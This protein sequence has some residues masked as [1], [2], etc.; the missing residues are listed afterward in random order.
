ML[1][2]LLTGFVVFALFGALVL[3][4][5]LHQPKAAELVVAAVA[6]IIAVLFLL[7]AACCLLCR[8]YRNDP[9][10]GPA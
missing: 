7:D 5:H 9:A 8:S 4:A 1:P 6:L 3:V 2:F 10:A